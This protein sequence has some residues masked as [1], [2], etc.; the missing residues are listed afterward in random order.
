MKTPSNMVDGCDQ[1]TPTIGITST[2]VIDP[3]AGAHGTIFVVA[4][5]RDFKR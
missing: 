5:T 2:P 1:V 3:T 4:M